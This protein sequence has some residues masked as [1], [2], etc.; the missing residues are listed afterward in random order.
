MIPLNTQPREKL[1]YREDGTVDVHSCFRTIQGEGPHAGRAAVFL[2]LAGCNLDCPGCDTDYTTGRR[3]MA[4]SDVVADVNWCSN[5]ACRLVVI[6]GGEPFRQNISGLVRELL[7]KGLHVQLETNGTVAP[8]DFP[9]SAD[10][11]DVV[12]SP[13]AG[14]VNPM[15]IQRARHCLT[16]KYVLQAGKVDSDGLPLSVLGNNVRVARPPVGTDK[17]SIFVQPMDE[18]DEHKNRANLQACRE[19]AER[20]GYRVGIQLHKLLG[21]D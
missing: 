20:F 3:R 10:S 7:A 12:C 9:W 4:V 15:L 13:K 6:T 21:V 1:D 16:F 8:D 19:S 14:G 5:T 2:R 17:G 11:L 18:Q